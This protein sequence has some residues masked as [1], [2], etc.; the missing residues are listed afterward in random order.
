MVVQ[1]T[2]RT[3]HAPVFPDSPPAAVRPQQHQVDPQVDSLPSRK[4]PDLEPAASILLELQDL[5]TRSPLAPKTYHEFQLQVANIVNWWNNYKRLLRAHP[6]LHEHCTEALWQ[7]EPG[8]RYFVVQLRRRM[9]STTWKNLTH[10]LDEAWME[11]NTNFMAHYHDAHKKRGR[12]IVWVVT[13]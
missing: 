13:R 4:N 6:E 10:P 8:L 5:A 9:T 12:R 2:P 3:E 11:L 1:S 7:H